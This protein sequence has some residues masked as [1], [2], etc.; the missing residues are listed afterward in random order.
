MANSH[1]DSGSFGDEESVEEKIGDGQTCH[2][3]WAE[4]CV[5]IEG[6]SRDGVCQRRDHQDHQI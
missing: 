4:A 2:P 6:T 3:A 1:L 5:R